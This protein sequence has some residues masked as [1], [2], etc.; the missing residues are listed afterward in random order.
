M[1]QLNPTPGPWKAAVSSP[2]LCGG[3]DAVVEAVTEDGTMVRREIC[4][5]LIDTGDGD[6]ES[7]EFLE[8]IDNLLLIASAPD[9]RDAL[10]GLRNGDCWCPRD[11]PTFYDHSASCEA[12][13]AAYLKAT[14]VED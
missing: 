11:W 2:Y 8:G 6:E 3:D 12:A 5:G 13:Q 4:T 10:A 7:P 1:R 14:T 9:L